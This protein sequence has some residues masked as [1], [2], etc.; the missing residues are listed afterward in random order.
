MQN[1]G[2]NGMK[3][4]GRNW[5]RNGQ[6]HFLPPQVGKKINPKNRE[7]FGTKTGI[8]FLPDWIIGTASANAFQLHLQ[9]NHID[10]HIARLAR[11]TCLHAAMCLPK[12]LL[13]IL[14]QAQVVFNPNSLCFWVV[15]NWVTTG[16]CLL[17]QV[18]VA[19]GSSPGQGY[20]S[21]LDTACSH[22]QW[23]LYVSIGMY[24][25]SIHTN[26]YPMYCSVLWYVLW[27]V[28]VVYIP[29]CIQY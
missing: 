9:V 17:Q 13:V 4:G 23:L 22:H 3:N 6:I 29:G 5:I 1:G 14:A 10:E 12:N 18:V 19:V 24:C 2:R 26:T 27:Y 16:Q 28:L 7:I 21:Y 20:S 11:D 15:Q 8:I 25:T